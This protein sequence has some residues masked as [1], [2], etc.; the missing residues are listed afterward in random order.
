MSLQTEIIHELGVKPT[1][2]PTEEIR[3][4][5][6]FMKAYLKK[7]PFLIKRMLS[8]RARHDNRPHRL[9]QFLGDVIVFWLFRN[10]FQIPSGVFD[11]R[12]VL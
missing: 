4:S 9:C 12:F 5:I 3:K 6:D 11:Q 10:L 7:Y 2:D 8:C 1:I